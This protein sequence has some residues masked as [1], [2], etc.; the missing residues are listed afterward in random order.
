L[1]LCVAKKQVRFSD[2]W[3]SNQY[4][5]KKVV[6]VLLIREVARLRLE[7]WLLL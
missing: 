7:H 3:I 5:L 6:I 4:D 1:V 2:P